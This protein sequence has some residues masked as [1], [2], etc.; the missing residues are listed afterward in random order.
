MRLFNLI[1]TRAKNVL[2]DEKLSAA[3]KLVLKKCDFVIDIGANNGQWINVVRRQGYN[4]PALC[5]EPLKKTI[6]N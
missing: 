2:P 3:R 6:L 5:I 1:L 4:G